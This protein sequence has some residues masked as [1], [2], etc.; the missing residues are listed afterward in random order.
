MKL[1]LK[2]VE[3]G[4]R[5]W[6][7]HQMAATM[8]KEVRFYSKVVPDM[9]KFLDSEGV[10]EEDLRVDRRVPRFYGAANVAGGTKIVL[11]L[12]DITDKVGSANEGKMD[13]Q[14]T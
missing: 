6:T 8:D 3:K 1:F 10:S 2:I 14:S 5:P 9:Q 7:S 11:V 12:E 4:T 13:L